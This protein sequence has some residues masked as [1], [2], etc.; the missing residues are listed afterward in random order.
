MASSSGH[1]V[2][3]IQYPRPAMVFLA[4]AIAAAA[5]HQD[6]AVC[7]QTPPADKTA[8]AAFAQPDWGR[9]T[10]RTNATGVIEL[11]IRSWPVDGKLS[12]PTPF[13]N[14]TAAR[15]LDGRRLEPLKWVFNPD[16]TLLH[17]ELPSAPPAHLPAIVLLETAGNT[18]QFADGRIV[19]SALDARVQG[20]HAKLES[21]PGNHRIGF[22]TDA[23]DSVSWQF[24]PT[25]WGHYDLELT[26]SADGGDGTELQ[27]E[28][29]GRTFTVTRPSTGSWYRYA[30][31]PIGRFYLAKSEPFTLRASCTKLTGAAAM[32]LKAIT[33]RPAPEGQPITQDA[34]GAITL[35]A[36]DAITH[37]VMMRYEPATNK[38]CLGYWVNPNDSAEWTFTVTQPGAFEVEL[39]QGCGKGQG[40]SEVVVELAGQKL[41][42]AVEETGHFQIFLP[43]RLGRVQ[44]PAPGTYSL[45]VRPQRKQAAAVMDLRQVRLVRVGSMTAASPAAKTF[46]E[47]R[48]VVFLGDSITYG[49]EYVEFIETYLRTR[50]PDARVELIN[51]G[52]PSETVSGLSEPGHAGGAFPRPDLHE[53]LGRVLDKLKP[54]LVVACYG[55]ND[56]I[57][58]PFAEERFQ[59]FQDGMRRLRDRVAAAG[60]KIIH[61]TPSPFDPLPLNGRTLPAGRAEYRS[62]YEGYNDVLDRYS[63]W[64][65]AQRAQG[66]E[67]IDAHGPMNRF[68][69]ERRRRDPAFHLAGDGVHVNAQGHWLIAREILKYLGAPDD[70]TSADDA[71]LLVSPY[72]RGA[73]VLKLVQQRQRLLKDAWL[74]DVGHVRPGMNKG[75]PLAEAEREAQE[76]DVR[77]RALADAQFPGRRSLWFGFDRFDFEVDG[78]PVLVVAPKQVAPGRPWVWQ[79]EFFGHKP[80]PDLALLG[81]GFHVVYLSV[82]DMLGGPEVVAHW[83]VFYR[84]LTTRFGLAKK[85][86][87]V[88][89]SRGGLY[90]YNWAEANPDK[91]ACIYGDAPVCDFKSW[92][93]GKGKGPGSP[94]DWQLVLERYHFKSEAEALAYD[95]NPVD[96]LA[97][98]AAAGVP[99]LHVYGDADEVVPWDEN[100]GVVAER[101]RK[102]GGS[103]ALIAK[104]GGKHHPHGLDDSTPIVN[105]IW[106]HAASPEA[107]AWLARHGGGP[108]DSEGRPLIRKSGTIDLDLVETTPV[109]FHGRL[110]RFE[111]VREGY[112]NN[113]RKTNYFR[114]VDHETGEPTP[115]FADGHEFGSA[116]VDGDTVYVTGTQGRSRVNLFA[117]R[118][119]KTWETWPV[120]ADGR[121]GIFN[122]SLCKAGGDYVLMFEIDRPAEEAGVPFTARFT[123]SRDLR[124]WTLTPPECNYAKDR[125][126]APHC[127][128]WLDGWFY[129]FYLEAHAGYETRVVRSRDLVHWE[130]SPLNPVLRASP[131]DKL[132]ANPNLTEPQRARLAQAVNLNNSDIDFCEWQGRLLFN[133]SWGNQQGVEHL[134]EAVYDGAL[135]QFLRGWFPEK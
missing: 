49:G 19:F 78:R 109:V 80:N 90:V 8:P 21:H 127:L 89:L 110:W 56:G 73:D 52:L 102:L 24:K 112:W 36:R 103:I 69:A 16:A 14:I 6:C 74:T 1:P 17:L 45:A 9:I 104:P 28:I 93:G 85:A 87:L 5:L 107:K 84:E 41:P 7:A 119:L 92:P 124:A 130:A 99:L 48:R 117:S 58:Y 118:D 94:R 62:P 70:L 131:E 11:E 113:R 115:P 123:R 10:P 59:K 27:F 47:A 72:P 132:V 34:S 97:P 33:L 96:N 13:A 60:S 32:N 122:T 37:S 95:K 126:T 71:G 44:L 133:Y 26:F 128:R 83:N 53:R 129:D 120:I 39:W 64:L 108:I 31:L 3:M 42:F 30:T 54:D 51:L 12:L 40:G 116:F 75:K 65:L 125:Y 79:G 43:R 61:V 101:Y 68:I 106:E 4:L 98:L 91:V 18:A 105:F 57:Y 67:V 50:F 38:N 77:I 35:A 2:G 22:W 81:R 88:G 76:L 15:L 82:P 23:A 134:A 100:T 114:F 86:A 25:R 55:M 29:A 135:E 121:Y 46:L 63:D 66:W 20:A 111:W